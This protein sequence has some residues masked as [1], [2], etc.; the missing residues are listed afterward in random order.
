MVTANIT[1]QHTGINSGTAVR[2]LA[3]KV[4]VAGKKNN[5]AK[6]DANGTDHTEVQTNTFENL[7]YNISGVHYDTSVANSLQY[8]DV[9]ILYKEK[10]NRGNAATLIVTYGNSTI[11]PNLAGETSGISVILD[12]FNFPIDVKDSRNGYMPIG[13]LSFIETK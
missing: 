8:T 4:T 11:L 12:D 5:T 10:Y 3:D 6:P 9:L 1:L 13:T 2:I 7:K